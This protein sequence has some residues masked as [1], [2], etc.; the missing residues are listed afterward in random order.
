MTGIPLVQILRDRGVIDMAQR[1]I[2]RVAD[3]IELQARSVTAG[4]A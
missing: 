4:A 2:A 3:R 1:I